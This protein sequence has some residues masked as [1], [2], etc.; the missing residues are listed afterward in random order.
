M[1]NTSL[2]ET[3]CRVEFD[4]STSRLVC[5]LKTEFDGGKQLEQFIQTYVNEICVALF[6]IRPT[7][8]ELVRLTRDDNR[9]VDMWLHSEMS[10]TRLAFDYND[11]TIGDKLKV[12]EDK[13]VKV[14]LAISNID[15]AQ[16]EQ[17]KAVGGNLKIS[18]GKTSGI[19]PYTQRNWTEDTH[20]VETAFYCFIDT[21]LTTMLENN[22][23]MYMNMYKANYLEQFPGELVYLASGKQVL[24]KTL[25][26][27]I[28]ESMVFNMKTPLQCMILFNT[29]LSVE[30]V[31]R[32]RLGDEKRILWNMQKENEKLDNHP[33][34]V[35][36]KIV[37]SSFVDETENIVK[38]QAHTTAQDIMKWANDTWNVDEWQLGLMGEN[39]QTLEAAARAV[40]MVD[41]SAPSPT[42]RKVVDKRHVRVSKLN[43]DK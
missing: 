25:K 38:M 35:G 37:A 13:K 7:S 27:L 28:E 23:K 24:P 9:L 18:P 39:G 22:I 19:D 17:I 32:N 11:S 15:R 14:S 20:V 30:G 5:T 8:S 6:F 2:Q 1:V 21:M 43:F 12:F 33:L 16:F 29:A 3:V 34:C 42:K 40:S 41:S 31:P 10:N 4:E 26:S 36:P